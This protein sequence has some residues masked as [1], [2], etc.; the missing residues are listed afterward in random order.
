MKYTDCRRI[1]SQFLAMLVCFAGISGLLFPVVAG[2]ITTDSP[3]IVTE[4]W[5]GTTI[6]TTITPGTGTSIVEFLIGNNDAG[7][8]GIDEINNLPTYDYTIWYDWYLSDG[9]THG[10]DGI[11][12][13]HVDYT[14]CVWGGTTAW[15]NEE[16]GTWSASGVILDWMDGVPGFEN[17]NKAFLWT[18]NPAFMN[19]SFHPGFTALTPGI[20]YYT[21]TGS[22]LSEGS[23]FAA[24]NLSGPT[25][26]GNTT[27]SVPEPSFLLLLGISSIGLLSFRKI[28]R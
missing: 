5:D 7:S 13:S 18:T 25:T 15:K 1:K 3:T 16:T 22:T 12:E 21:F 2:A 17:Y 23:P 27:Q 20:T 19:T 6:H 4:S 8:A 9:T 28:K 10:M 14:E 26:Y 11:F 24:H